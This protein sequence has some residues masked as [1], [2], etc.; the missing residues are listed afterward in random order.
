MS[1]TED[2]QAL[3]ILEA[4]EWMEFTACSGKI[5]CV[6]VAFVPAEQLKEIC[7]LAVSLL[8]TRCKN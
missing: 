2:E 3:A 5:T 8:G 1:Y 7:S 6:D 4:V